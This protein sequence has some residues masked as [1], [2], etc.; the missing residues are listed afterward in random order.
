LFF[1][2]FTHSINALETIHTHRAFFSLFSVK[3]FLTARA[4]TRSPSSSTEILN[5]FGPLP[6]SRSL[7]LSSFLFLLL[8]LFSHSTMSRHIAPFSFSNFNR[9]VLKVSLCASKENISVT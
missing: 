1:W 7:L 5:L 9:M 4:R 6:P 8:S 2:N 3:N